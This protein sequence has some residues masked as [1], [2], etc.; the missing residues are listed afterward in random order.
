MT[1]VSGVVDREM[2]PVNGMMRN[3]VRSTLTPEQTTIAG[4]IHKMEHLEIEIDEKS[5]IPVIASVSSEDTMDEHATEDEIQ[6]LLLRETIIAVSN[7]DNHHHMSDRSQSSS[8]GIRHGNLWIVSPWIYT[9]TGGWGVI[10][11]HWF[12]PPCVMAIL[13]YA[14]YYF[15]ISR[16]YYDLHRIGSAWICGIACTCSVFHLFHASYRDPGIIVPGRY[17]IPDPVPRNYRWCDICHYYQP[18][19]AAHCPECN[20]CIAGYD[21]HCV[22]MGTCIGVG[23]F[24]PFM[25]FNLC[26]LTYFIYAIVWITILAP[27]Y[28]RVQENHHHQN[29]TTTTNATNYTQDTNITSNNETHYFI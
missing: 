24:K 7:K 1:S 4:S 26:W 29:T 17:S 10:G 18:P 14:T 25:R 21:H 16:C 15:G 11:P 2:V 8:F 23:N 12:G 19:S 6:S 5:P 9:H 27:L 22:W 13:V 3:N 20:V 28:D